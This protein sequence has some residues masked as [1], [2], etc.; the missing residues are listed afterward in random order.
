MNIQD[1]ENKHGDSIKSNFTEFFGERGYELRD[2]AN[3][4]DGVDGKPLFVCSGMQQFMDAFIKGSL[5]GIKDEGVITIQPCVR[6][7][8][9]DSDLDSVGKDP[10]HTSKFTMLGHFTFGYGNDRDNGCYL[11]EHESAVCLVMGFIG[12]ILG[13]YQGLTI[14][15][16]VSGMDLPF[17]HLINIQN[18]EQSWNAEY[19]R[20][21]LIGK[22]IEIFYNDIELWNIVKVHI[23]GENGELAY[24]GIDSGGGLGR[25]CLAKEMIEQGITIDQVG[26]PDVAIDLGATIRQLLVEGLRPGAKGAANQLRK[27]IRKLM[28]YKGVGVDPRLKPDLVDELVN[29]TGEFKDVLNPEFDLY[30]EYLYRVHRMQNYLR[31]DLIDFLNLSESPFGKTFAKKL[32]QFAEKYAKETLGY[33]ADI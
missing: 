21:K 12:C 3:I 2:P 30:V 14:K 17:A 27:L 31:R 8:G 26:N 5:S 24:R 32:I 18:C 7:E 9:K 15:G 33:D 25:L 13:T 6:I 28:S 20:G 22:S 29:Y 11:Y 1:A 10:T 19:D 16:D 23:L 4:V